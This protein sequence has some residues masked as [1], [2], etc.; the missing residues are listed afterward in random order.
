[1]PEAEA[2]GAAFWG[3]AFVGGSDLVSGP[4]ANWEPTALSKKPPP[5]EPA[6]EGPFNLTMASRNNIQGSSVTELHQTPKITLQCHL[7]NQKPLLVH[8]VCCDQPKQHETCLKQRLQGQ[9]F[10]VQP[11]LRSQI[12][13]QI[14][15]QT[16]S[17]LR[18]QRNLLQKSLQWKSH[19]LTTMASRN[20]QGSFVTELHQTPKITLQCHLAN[21]KPLLVH[22]VCCDQP[23]QHETCL[24]QRLQ[25]QPFWVQPLSGSQ[26]LAQICLRTGTPLRCQKTPLLKRQ[27]W[28]GQV[29]RETADR[30]K[31]PDG[32]NIYLHQTPKLNLPCLLHSTGHFSCHD[33]QM[34]CEMNNQSSISH[35]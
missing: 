21:Q 35:A 23:K 28:K 26:I 8:A 32:S 1:M 25:G 29:V 13:A 11:L 27:Q 19:L 16:G 14:C 2:A 5:E 15:L 4:L 17:P 31:M 20:I 33:A 10:R 12:L 9:H 3:A 6:M 22:A 7:A 34:P 18:C 24:K 30:I